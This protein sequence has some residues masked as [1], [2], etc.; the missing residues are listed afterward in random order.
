LGRNEDQRHHADQLKMRLG[1]PRKRLGGRP[2]ARQ[3]AQ[4]S[5]NGASTASGIAAIKGC[6]ASFSADPFVL[7]GIDAAG[8]DFS[9]RYPATCGA[10]S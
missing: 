3:I 6:S 7:S 9:P 4:S 1:D 10:Q 8:F 5:P 2:S